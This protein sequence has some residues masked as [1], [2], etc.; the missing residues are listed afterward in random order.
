MMQ[1]QTTSM[2][3]PYDQGLIR[4]LKAYYWDKLAHLLLTKEA[5]DVSLCEGLRVTE[6]NEAVSEVQGYSDEFSDVA[7]LVDIE[8]TSKDLTVYIDVITNN[9]LEEAGSEGREDGINERYPVNDKSSTT[10]SKYLHDMGNIT[11]GYIL[12]TGKV[13]NSVSEVEQVL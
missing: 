13:T 6:L 1:K 3:Q 8:T 4:S 11:R 9:T 10:I 2:L 12:S 5:K 7:D